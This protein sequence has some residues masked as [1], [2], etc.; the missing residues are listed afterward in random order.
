MK[1]RYSAIQIRS[2][3]VLAL[4]VLLAAAPAHAADKAQLKARFEQR[5]PQVL[6]YKTQ[7]KI[8]ETTQG[9]L[10]AV[11]A[12]YMDDARL[13]GLVNEENADRRELYQIIATETGTTPENVAQRM[14]RRNFERARPGE[15]LKGADGKWQ[16]KA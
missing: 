2:V 15:Y 16:R 9:V 6:E 11:D 4:G 10:E 7:G 3:V 12:K 8:G 14:A 13:A 1:N 5:Y